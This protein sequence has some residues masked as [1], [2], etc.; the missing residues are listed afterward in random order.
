MWLTLLFLFDRKMFSP[1]TCRFANC[2]WVK[3]DCC[4][5]RPCWNNFFP[6]IK[7]RVLTFLNAIITTAD[8]TESCER[9]FLWNAAA[10][11]SY[12]IIR[13]FE[14]RCLNCVWFSCCDAGR[15]SWAY[16]LARLRPDHPALLSSFIFK[17]RPLDKSADLTQRFVIWTILFSPPP[18]SLSFSPSLSLLLSLYI[19]N[20]L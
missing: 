19:Y 6:F 15:D 14:R 11:L 4:W 18:P 16:S 8:D 7:Y 13:G 9:S 3:L 10:F 2:N 1:A 17:P 20:D 12:F 5:R